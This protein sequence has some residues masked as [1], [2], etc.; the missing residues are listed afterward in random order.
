[1]NLRKDH[2]HASNI[3]N[4]KFSVWASGWGWT[5]CCLMWKLEGR[6]TE[7][8]LPCCFVG[9]TVCLAHTALRLNLYLFVCA[10]CMYHNF[11]RWMPRLEQRWRAQ[12]S[13]IIFV[14][15]RIPWINRALNV[16]CAFGLY[17]KACLRWCLYGL[18]Q[19]ATL[20]LMGS[21]L[22]V[23]QCVQGSPLLQRMHAFCRCQQLAVP[24]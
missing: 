11:Q 9:A 2:S 5:K 15:C 24:V 16:F 23:C 8:V 6:W 7:A 18:I 4:L 21:V 14:N 20:N 12:R 13:V 1:M 19:S 3:H 17:L 22:I 10:C